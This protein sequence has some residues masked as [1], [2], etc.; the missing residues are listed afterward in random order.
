MADQ[1]ISGS[2]VPRISGSSSSV[3]FH[4]SYWVV[5]GQFLAGC[6]PGSLDKKEADRKLRGLISH[7]IRHVINLMELDEFNWDRESFKPYEGQMTAVAD[8]MGLDVT[9]ER[10]PIMDGGVSAREDMVL[11]LDNIDANIKKGKPVYIHCWGGRGRTGTVVGCYLI[12]HGLCQAHQAVDRIR[13]LRKHTGD[14][15][16]PSPESRR[17]FEMVLSWALGSRKL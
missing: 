10:R 8:S 2:P 7:G 11:I 16:E 1:V 15:G 4:R 6:Y 17:Q 5:P 14:H 3:P 12:R 9:F 13:E